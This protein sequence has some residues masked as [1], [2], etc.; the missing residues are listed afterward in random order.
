[1]RNVVTNTAALPPDRLLLKAM[2]LG[3]SAS[4]EA[5]EAQGQDEFVQSDVMPAR[6]QNFSFLGDIDHALQRDQ[7]LERLGFTVSAAVAGDPLFIFASLPPGWSKRRNENHSMWSYIVDQHGRERLSCFY[8]AAHYDR[9]AHFS[10]EG[11][12]RVD[13][14]YGPQIDQVAVLGGGQVLR[15]FGSSSNSEAQSDARTWA[16]VTFPDHEDPLAYW[17]LSQADIGAMIG[18][19]CGR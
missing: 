4:V 18:G 8:K 2:V 19:D 15:Q 5:M 3:V 17:D 12:L 1:M 16:Q 11:W 14:Y 10:V 7:L 13:A 9:K 6:C